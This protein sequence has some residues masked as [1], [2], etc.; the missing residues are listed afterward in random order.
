MVKFYSKVMTLF[1]LCVLGGTSVVA[2]ECP[3]GFK[4]PSYKTRSA[5]CSTGEYVPDAYNFGKKILCERMEVD[6]LIPLKLAHCAGLSDE[7]LKRLANDPKN[8]RFTLMKTNRSKGAK[9]LYSFVQTLDPKMQKKVLIDGVNLMNDYEI[10]LSPQ[11][12][13]EL[14]SRLARSTRSL[15]SNLDPVIKRKMRDVLE[16]MTRRVGTSM[17]RGIAAAQPQAATGVLAPMALAMIAW[18]VYDACQ[19]I[20]DLDELKQINSETNL[21]AEKIDEEDTCGMSRAEIFQA[22]TGKDAAF[23]ECVKSRLR[24]GDS[25]TLECKDYPIELPHK[26]TAES[27]D[28]S[29]EL[30]HK[31]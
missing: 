10:R 11:L 4:R 24:T 3:L 29:L 17:A 28:I 25:D 31:Q 23:E 13:K 2:Q 27:D 6:H 5:Y 8:L 1:L 19:Q 26:T 16:R 7:Q 9:D 15:S 18:E 12:S 22:F 14:T 20:K 30:P 21:T